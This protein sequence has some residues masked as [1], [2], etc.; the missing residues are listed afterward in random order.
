MSL[1]DLEVKTAL[2]KD[3]KEKRVVLFPIGV[4]RGKTR[5]LAKITHRAMKLL[6]KS[7]Q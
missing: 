4:D 2:A 3:R 1:R 7:V 6:G 5:I